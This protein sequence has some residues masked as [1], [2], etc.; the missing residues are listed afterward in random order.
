MLKCSCKLKDEVNVFL[1]FNEVIAAHA[2]KYPLMEAIDAIKLAYQS[3]FGAG[4][5]INDEK[6]AKKYFY[7]ELSQTPANPTVPLFESV[8]GALV[9]VNFAALTEYRLPPERLFSAF[10]KTANAVK[11]TR[12][13]FDKKL[14]ELLSYKGFHFSALTLKSCIEKYLAL[15][16]KNGIPSPVSHSEAYRALYAPHYRIVDIEILKSETEIISV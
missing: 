3:E 1:K 13:G 8:G 7:E 2:E 4:H 15:F 12:Q 9:R 6:E 5:F 14:A 11:G 16:E 10:V